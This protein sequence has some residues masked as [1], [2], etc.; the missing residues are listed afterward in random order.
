MREAQG[1]TNSP[2]RKSLLIGP[3]RLNVVHVEPDGRTYSKV[4]V[5]N[6]GGTN[7]A[8][9]RCVSLMNDSHDRSDEILVGKFVS[10]E[11]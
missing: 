7:R 11:G 4:V 8:L 1:I 6:E 2:G 9:M 3:G 5:I 10:W